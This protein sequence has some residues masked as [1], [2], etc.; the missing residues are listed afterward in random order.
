MIHIVDKEKCCGCGACEQIC[1][2]QCIV[3]VEDAEGFLYPKVEM[4]KCVDCGLCQRVCLEGH[5][6][7]PRVPLRVLAAQNIDEKIRLESSSGGIFTLLA[8]QIIKEG[9]IVFGARFNQSWEVVH[10]YAETLE[11]LKD[12]RGSKYVQS[13]IGQSYRNAETFLKA[14]RK[15]LFS[16][17]PCQIA[18]LKRYLRKSY[19]HLYTVDFICHGVPSP[20]VWRRYLKEEIARQCDK[21]S[22]SHASISTKDAR[23]KG[24]CHRDKS[25][26]WQKYSFAL[27]LSVTGGNGENT[28]SLCISAN[29]NPYLKGFLCN[30]YL[31]PSCYRCA[32]RE[33]RGGSDL[34]MADL[35]GKGICSDMDDDKGTSAVYVHNE[36]MLHGSL[37][38]RVKEISFEPAVSHNPSWFHSVEKRK[39]RELFFSRCEKEGAL[40]IPLITRYAPFSFS[41]KLLR[42]MK[43]IFKI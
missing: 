3:L 21:N 34:T 13:F 42:Y 35:W 4:E 29:K 31:R 1:P 14:G 25:N 23:I 20:M 11:R 39:R 2:R 18:G 7:E 9:G 28:V 22:V 27:Q 37:N 32:F 17:T 38:W 16:G 10:G 40:V 5:P 43:R 6:V 12:F 19:D 8:E 15:V 24:I 36:R 33:G 30:L 41:E 26:G